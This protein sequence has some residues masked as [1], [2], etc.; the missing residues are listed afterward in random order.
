MTNM[1]NS[2]ASERA[3]ESA[4]A[5]GLSWAT[6]QPL[7]EAFPANIN[8]DDLWIPV[9]YDEAITRPDLWDGPIKKEMDRL[10]EHRV[11]HLVEKPAGTNIMKTKWVFNMKFDGDGRISSWKAHLVAKGFTQ[12]PGV[13]FFDTYAS[14]VRYETLQM[15]L[16]IAAA[17]GWKTCCM[18]EKV[19]MDQPQGMVVEGSEGMI[20]M[21]DFSLYGTMQGAS[22]WWDKLDGTCCDLG[23]KRS[24]ADQSV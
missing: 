16:A 9:S 13:N 19:Y 18:K 6:D 10:R 5:D 22:N 12:I 7:S 1:Q 20:A 23:Y 2:I 17:K 21:L 8:P 4:A 15:T 24:H 3:I 11:W 14:V